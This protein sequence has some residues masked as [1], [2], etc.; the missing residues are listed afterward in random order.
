MGY[1]K[2]ISRILT[3]SKIKPFINFVGLC[4]HLEEVFALHH[5]PQHFDVFDVVSTSLECV[6][7]GLVF[8]VSNLFYNI[9]CNARKSTQVSVREI[10]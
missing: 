5:S 9:S 1:P 8:L 2:N 4:L 10:Y 3:F 7:S 6:L